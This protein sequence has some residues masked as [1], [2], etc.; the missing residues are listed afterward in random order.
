MGARITSKELVG[1]LGYKPEGLSSVNKYGAV[2]KAGALDFI[3]DST[4]EAKRSSKIEATIEDDNTELV[5]AGKEPTS[6]WLRQVP[7]WLGPSGAKFVADFLL[8]TSYG[9]WV[10]EV[11]GHRT[12]K[13]KLIEKLWEA[14]GPCDMVVST[15]DA[16]ARQ[17]VEKRIVGGRK[18]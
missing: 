7:F 1:L 16:K 14:H 10:D 18:P 3:Y 5:K 9:V 2:K 12:P 4:M 6:F 15:L 13:W 8:I 17:W 11:K